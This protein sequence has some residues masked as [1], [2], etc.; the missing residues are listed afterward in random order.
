MARL[1]RPQAAAWAG[2]GHIAVAAPDAAGIADH[3]GSVWAARGGTAASVNGCD[4]LRGRLAEGAGAA[5]STTLCRTP[6][7][8]ADCAS[9]PNA[10]PGGACFAT[11]GDCTASAA[12]ATSC[13]GPRTATDA[14]VAATRRDGRKSAIKADTATRHGCTAA[15]AACTAAAAIGRA[16]AIATA[17]IPDADE[18]LVRYGETAGTHSA[19]HVVTHTEHPGLLARASPGRH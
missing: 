10:R 8:A 14:A 11:G 7:G 15:T 16:G 13:P 19:A 9:C 4:G 12:A 2:T 17:G 18:F 6:I 3:D 5:Q 1:A